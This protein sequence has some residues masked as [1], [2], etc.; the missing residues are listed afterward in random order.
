MDDKSPGPSGD[1]IS[2]WLVYQMCLFHQHF[3]ATRHSQATGSRYSAKMNDI[4]SGACSG[5]DGT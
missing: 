5:G 1:L 3:L 4:Y 2:S